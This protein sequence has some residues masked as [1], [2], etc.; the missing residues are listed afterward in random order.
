M[1]TILDPSALENRFLN[2]HKS[3]LTT[4]QVSDIEKQ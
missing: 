3:L 2:L 4:F 1:E